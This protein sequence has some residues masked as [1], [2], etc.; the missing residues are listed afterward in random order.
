MRT[1]LGTLLLSRD[2]L[3]LAKFLD[4]NPSLSLSHRGIAILAGYSFRVGG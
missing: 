4:T 3:G 1:I 2:D